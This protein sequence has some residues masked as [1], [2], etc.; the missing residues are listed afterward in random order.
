[1]VCELQKASMFKRISAFLVDIIIFCLVALELGVILSSLLG[2][3]NTV[4]QLE[5]H[6]ARYE[7]LYSIDTQIS[8][9]EYRALSDKDKARYDE[10]T[11]AFA[12]DEAVSATYTM[13]MNK[14][15]I[16]ASISMLITFVITEFAMPMIFKHG[17]TLGKRL[18]GV[19][20]MRTDGVK[21]STFQV[22]VRAIFGK[23]TIET[24][25]PVLPFL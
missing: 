20:V 6:Y 11:K 9:E 17:R 1:M 23:F 15:L 4:G 18:F 14:T 5:A 2:Y 25:L 16:I 21:V 7:E 3:K 12:E 19:A 24:M 22:F 13:L 8:E 10:A